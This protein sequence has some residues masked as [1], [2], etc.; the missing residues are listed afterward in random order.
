MSQKQKVTIM[1]I[2]RSI[3]QVFYYI[4]MIIAP[5]LFVLSIVTS[6]L[7]NTDSNWLPNHAQISVPAIIEYTYTENG[8]QRYATLT[9]PY[10][11]TAIEMTEHPWQLLALQT[12]SV[13][14]LAISLFALH[15]VIE[16]LKSAESSTAFTKQN[17][18]RVR[19]IGTLI[20]LYSLFKWGT[21]NLFVL[22]IAHKSIQFSSTIQFGIG[23]PEYSW[24]MAGLLIYILGY[25]F[26]SGRK[27]QE[28]QSLT[29]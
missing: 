19:N 27:L 11:D 28:D 12:S 16:L 2:A 20:I 14:L 18:R 17:A 4:G 25:I 9:A 8:I 23:G 22:F 15:Q 6:V 3:L 5:L 7:P 1:R 13:I 10:L 21:A 26:D 24:L 29:V